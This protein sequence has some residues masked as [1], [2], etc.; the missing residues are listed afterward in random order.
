MKRVAILVVAVS[1]LM[2]AVRWLVGDRGDAVTDVTGGA[3][4]ASRPATEETSTARSLDPATAAE[5]EREPARDARPADPAETGASVAGRVLD[6]EGRP[7]DGATVLLGGHAE[8]VRRFGLPDIHRRLDGE[9]AP[10]WTTTDADGRF[11]FEG[12]PPRR[13]YWLRSK[14]PPWLVAVATDL[15]VGEEDVDAGVLSLEAG[16]RVRGVVRAASGRTHE[17]VRVDVDVALDDAV[18]G[19]DGRFD[20]TI[21]AGI[22]RVDARREGWVQRPPEPRSFL[23]GTEVDLTITLER[24]ASIRGRVADERGRP[25]AGASVRAAEARTTSDARGEFEIEAGPEGA[26]IDL[27][28]DHPEHCLR[29]RRDVPA[30]TSDLRVTLAAADPVDVLCRDGE[31]R[32]VAPDRLWVAGFDSPRSLARRPSIPWRPAV[33]SAAAGE[34]TRVFVSGSTYA[35]VRGRTAGGDLAV[36]GPFRLGEEAAEAT[37]VFGRGIDVEVA[38]VDAHDGTPVPGAEVFADS[39]EGPWCDL[40]TGLTRADSEGRAVLRALGPGRW[41]PRARHREYAEVVDSLLL[42]LG[43]G[44]APPPTVRVALGRPSSVRGTLLDAHDRPV[45][46]WPLVAEPE[47]R[48]GPESRPGPVVTTDEDGRF[49][50]DRKPPGTLRLWTPRAGFEVEPVGAGDGP[51]LEVPAGE[52]IDVVAR[53]VRVPSGAVVVRVLAAGGPAPDRRVVL[54][55]VGRHSPYECRR[56]ATD[57]GGRAAFA[58]LSP[59]RWMAS[60]DDAVGPPRWT[61]VEV[62]DGATAEVGVHLDLGSIDLVFVDA[63]TGR[64]VRGPGTLRLADPDDRSSNPEAWPRVLSPDLRIDAGGRARVLDVVPARYRL[65]VG[66]VSGYHLPTPTRIEVRPGENLVLTVPLA[67]GGWIDLHLEGAPDQLES[68]R[69]RILDAGGVYLGTGWELSPRPG[70]A[71]TIPVERG[72]ASGTLL[73]VGKGLNGR[74]VWRGLVPIGPDADGR[75]GTVVVPLALE[76]R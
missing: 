17:A 9:S 64:P 60:L 8:F 53:L 6:A 68:F 7:V 43:A 35:A 40:S 59:G 61:E 14:A 32:P 57:A 67:P 26:P 69:W 24:A 71:Q 10:R 58:G 20:L 36:A 63:T 54:A 73:V 29:L 27:T 45:P 52:T 22:R 39:F 15:D 66:E 55:P 49:E 19:P 30:G 25:I 12:V 74:R 75:F 38:V 56:A 23:A 16:T 34:P 31:G 42:R 4:A 51:L 76:D 70:P 41:L 44:D 48:P 33:P 65:L 5:R 47:R 3:P 46:R 62:A 21:P 1:T 11:R 50:F 18:T 72:I 28:F 2:I 13:G 37:L